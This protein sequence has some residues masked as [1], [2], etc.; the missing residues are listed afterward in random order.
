MQLYFT[1][2]PSGPSPEALSRLLPRVRQTRAGSPAFPGPGA[3]LAYALLAYG[4]W[5]SHGVF[6]TP[7][8]VYEVGGKPVFQA[9]APH[10]SLSH[11]KTH[12]LCA[13]SRSPVGVDIETHRA[14]SPTVVRRVLAPWEAP[15]DFFDY[16]TLKESAIKLLGKKERP[17]R[18]MGFR[19]AGPRAFW[20]EAGIVGALYR[21]APGCSAA[22]CAW[23]AFT[24]PLLRFVPVSRLL[25]LAENG[26]SENASRP[27]IQF[28]GCIDA[29]SSIQSKYSELP[30]TIGNATSSGTS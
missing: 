23:E 22:V 21:P 18:E 11:G 14:V 26:A 6:Q 30:S 7:G 12:V 16:W 19:R 1:E 29:A 27:P 28:S 15:E 4:L 24:A 5:E 13:I 10:F 17:F 9:G 8:I 20:P 25:A 2:I 3:L